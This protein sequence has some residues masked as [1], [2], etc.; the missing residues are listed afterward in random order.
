MRDSTPRRVGG[1]DH[2]LIDIRFDCSRSELDGLPYMDAVI[3]EVLR[4]RSPV[5]QTRRDSISDTAIPLGTPIRG[6]DGTMLDS[7]PAAKGTSCM[8]CKCSS[9]VM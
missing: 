7:V 1:I 2:K 8:I 3:H 6:K 9:T 5:P 4:L